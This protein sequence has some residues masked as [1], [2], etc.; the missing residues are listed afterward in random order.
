MHRLKQLRYDHRKA[1]RIADMHVHTELGVHQLGGLLRRCPNQNMHRFERLW[2]QHGKAGRISDMHSV[3][4]KL[5]M[6]CMG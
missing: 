2:N 1:G 5:A 4:S 6:Q 3:H